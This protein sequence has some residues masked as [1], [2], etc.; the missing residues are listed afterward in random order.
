ME[1]A[2]GTSLAGYELESVV[3]HGPHGIVYRADH[4][5]LRRPCALKAFGPELARDSSLRESLLRVAAL[6]H[7]HIVP[8]YDVDD[9]DGMLLVSRRLVHGWNLAE[10]LDARD[11]PTAQTAAALLDQVVSALEAAHEQE[12]VHG[13]LKPANIVIAR[14][15]RTLFVT[16]FGL[17][18]HV[19]IRGVEGAGMIGLAPELLAGAELDRRADV[20][21][22]GWLLFLLLSDRSAIAPVRARIAGQVS[23]P[24]DLGL[25]RADVP[26]GV[27]AV[28]ATAIARRPADRYESA[29]AFGDAMRQALAGASGAEEVAIDDDVQFT[30]YRRD[31]VQPGV[32]YPLLA[33]A[34]KTEPF[35]DD[36]RGRV[37]PREQV[38]KQAEAQL[39]SDVGRYRQ[40]SQDSSRDLPRGSVLTFVP[41]VEGVEFRPRKREFTWL[42]PVHQE[43]FQMR[44]APAVDGKRVRGTL[45]VYLGVVLIAE[46]TLAFK[47][48]SGEPDG[49]VGS[50]STRP[51][52]KI[53][54]SYAHADAAIVERVE[55]VLSVLGDDL[56]RDARDLRSGE[57]WDER[58]EEMIKEADIFQLYWS[59]NS[60]DSAHVQNEWRYALSL[61]RAHFIRPFYWEEPRPEL[62]ERNLPPP[63]LSRIQFKYLPDVLQLTPPAGSNVTAGPSPDAPVPPPPSA[64]APPPAPEAAPAPASST[65]SAPVVVSRAWTLTGRQLMRYPLIAVIAL[66]LAVGIPVALS[67][68]GGGGTAAAP[69]SASSSDA[70]PAPSGGAGEVS[71][72]GGAFVAAFSGTGPRDLGAMTKKASRLE[73]TSSG[74]RFVLK[75]DHRAAIESTATQGAIPLSEPSYRD[76][77]VD[78]QGSWS[79]HFL[80]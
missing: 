8:V 49:S 27:A 4:I 45:S 52:R 14:D 79:V 71:S 38:R 75:L 6:R 32:W 59:T 57:V 34:H 68:H 39:G 46:L 13:D 9:H 70:T 2:V 62:P 40:P 66:A 42:Q 61:G 60:M 67:K 73:W 21:S 29:A 50:D 12:L 24:P 25:L 28:I 37:D 19:I 63:E 17:P 47:V 23:E 64:S 56:L 22:L 31:S 72:E 7:E 58:L 76:V 5:R 16:D 74:G 36:V 44:A 18:R 43:E 3:G 53:F 77:S 65:S 33:F 10:W 69:S 55:P 15:E 48:G 11:P 80:K 1:L 35:V 78:T 54:I 30:V 41:E 51:Y 26:R 20:Y